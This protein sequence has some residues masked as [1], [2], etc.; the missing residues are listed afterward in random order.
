MNLKRKPAKSLTEAVRR[1]ALTALG[2]FLPFALV[3]AAVSFLPVNS[4]WTT[5]EHGANA[6]TAAAHTARQYDKAMAKCQTLPANTLPGAAV[7]GWADGTVTYTEDA[8]GV[9]TAFKIALGELS[10]PAVSGVTLCR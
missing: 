5:P 1:G 7:I 10:D 4:A 6:D 8:V 3:M 9:D 2:A